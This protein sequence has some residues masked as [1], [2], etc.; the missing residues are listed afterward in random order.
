MLVHFHYRLIP[1][2]NSEYIKL[3][4]NKIITKLIQITFTMEVIAN[5]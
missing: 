1:T 3:V 4:N 2:A 5:F